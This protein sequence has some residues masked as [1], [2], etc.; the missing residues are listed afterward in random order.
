[1]NRIRKAIVGLLLAASLALPT[2]AFAASTAGNTT[3]T[4]TVA[5]T[6]SMTVPATSAWTL[7]GAVYGSTA[8]VVLS[9]IGT[10][11]GTGLTITVTVDA[12]SGAGSV[13]TTARHMYFDAPTGAQAASLTKGA[14]VAAGG[15]TNTSTSKT[16]ASSTVALSGV[17]IGVNSDVQASL[18]PTAGSYTTAAHY[19]ATTN[20]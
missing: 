17:S 1:M 10:N 2:G 11:G 5:A 14:D 16:V 7:Q 4:F 9:N 13:P 8:P 15:F 6:I 3:E 18:F 19:T 12:F 20:P